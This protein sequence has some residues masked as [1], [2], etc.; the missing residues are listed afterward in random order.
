MVED[1]GALAAALADDLRA[2]GFA[3][4]GPAA[5]LDDGL[6]M[7]QSR[8]FDAALLDINLGRETVYPLAQRLSEASV[9]FVLLTAYDVPDV[10]AE[11]AAAPV[12]SKPASPNVIRD[13]LRAVLHAAPLASGEPAEPMRDT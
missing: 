3:V 4:V 2:W 1:N 8:E 11:L 5:T 7:A 9:P 13:T 10:P 6:H 12:L